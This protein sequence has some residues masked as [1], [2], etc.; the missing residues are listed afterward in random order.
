MAQDKSILI[1]NSKYNTQLLTWNFKHATWI[2][3]E[4]NQ[5]YTWDSYTIGEVF[6]W[7]SKLQHMKH[8]KSPAQ[9]ALDRCISMRQIC[10]ANNNQSTLI[11]GVGLKDLHEI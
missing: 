8:Q 7:R 5:I 4:L 6:L 2:F 9:H 1:I 11:G 3:A 10:F